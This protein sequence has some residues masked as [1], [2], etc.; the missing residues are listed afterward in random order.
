MRIK[1]FC[2]SHEV[3]EAVTALRAGFTV[4]SVGRPVRTGNVGQP[5]EVSVHAS[6]A[7]RREV[8]SS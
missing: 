1:L 3:A 7:I 8:A 5:G 4:T 6:V 2:Q